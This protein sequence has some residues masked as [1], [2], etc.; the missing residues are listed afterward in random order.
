MI[1]QLLTPTHLAILVVPLLLFGPR[2]LPHPATP[3][4]EPCTSSETG[5][6]AKP[7]HR[8]VEPA[9]AP[10]HAAHAEDAAGQEPSPT[11]NP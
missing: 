10:P 7:Q 2:R 8:T 5:S 3:S 9:A 4:G 11:T 6:P 1:T